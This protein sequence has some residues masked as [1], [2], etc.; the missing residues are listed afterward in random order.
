MKTSGLFDLQVNGYA[1]VDFNDVRLTAEA[2]E[3]ALRAMLDAG[4]THCLPTIITASE[5]LMAERLAALDRAVAGSRL[6]RLMV[7]GLHLE[8]PFLNPAAGYAG[9]H[10]A[11]EMVPPDPALLERIM[12]GLERPVLVVTL[13][14][15]REGAGAVIAWLRARGILAAI[16]HSAASPD[17]VSRAA[18]QG[19]TLSVHLG[20][21]MAALQPKFANPMMAQLADDRLSASFIADGIHIPPHALRVMVRAKG[22]ERGLLVTDA[23]AAAGSAPGLY[24]MAGMAIERDEEGAVRLPGGA[25]LA[26]SALALDDAVRNVVGWGVAAPEQ[27][28]RMASANPLSVLAPALRA[29]GVELEPSEVAWSHDLRPQAVRVGETKV[30]PA[31]A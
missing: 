13:A 14:P 23:T 11:R 3:H 10:P 2:L 18:E 26:G 28:L 16:G 19:A 20:N 17:I 30:A 15:E 31:Y 6:G 21:G 25:T 1:G 4:V 29:H 7:P 8:G 24:E 9:C 27:A 12:R 5:Q 22:A